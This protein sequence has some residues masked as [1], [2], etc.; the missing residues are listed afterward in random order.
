MFILCS[1]ILILL[2]GE[3]RVVFEKV[4]PCE[5]TKNHS[6]QL[7]IFINKT[8]SRTK[9]YRGNL[10]FLIPFD[11]TLTVST[12]HVMINLIFVYFSETSII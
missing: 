3:Y 7:N 10:T 5:T 2:Q 8:T 11:D 9:E 12:Y 6:I 4:Y 1:Y